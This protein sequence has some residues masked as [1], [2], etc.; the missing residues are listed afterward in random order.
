MSDENVKEFVQ[1]TEADINKLKKLAMKGPD[2]PTTRLLIKFIAYQQVVN[3]QL[4]GE[5]HNLGGLVNEILQ[6]I[7]NSEPNTKSEP[8]IIEV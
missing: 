1:I 3:T 7:Q 5:I 6:A 4:V 2:D 8:K